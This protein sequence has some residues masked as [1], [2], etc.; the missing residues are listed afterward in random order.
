M[1]ITLLTVSKWRWKLAVFSSSHRRRD[2]GRETLTGWEALYL[3]GVH[4]VA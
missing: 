1:T 3:C 2:K 4:P